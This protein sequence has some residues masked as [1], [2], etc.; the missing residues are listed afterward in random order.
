MLG[1]IILNIAVSVTEPFDL[2]L[3][4]SRSMHAQQLP[5]TVCLSS[6]MLIAQAVFLL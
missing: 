3:S 4:T 1:I 5:F 2:D 6:L